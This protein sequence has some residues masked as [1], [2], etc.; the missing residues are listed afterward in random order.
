MIRIIQNSSTV[1]I[2]VCALLVIQL[3]GCGGDT[4]GV[5]DVENMS[6]APPL[7]PDESVTV[8]LSVFLGEGLATADV[9]D[10][11][12][13]VQAS[14]G[15][16][17]PISQ[18]NFTIAAARAAI[19]NAAVGAALTPPAGLFVMAKANDP[20]LQADGSWLWSYSLTYEYF[21][22]D[23]KL[24]G[25]VDG[26]KTY[27]SMKMSVDNPILPI[28]DFEWY[29][30]V[31]TESNLSGS[32]QFFDI[33][34]PEEKN[35]TVEIDWSVEVLK[36]KAELDIQNVDTRSEYL[37]DVLHYNVTSEMASMSFQDVSEG[38][39]W[40]ITWDLETGAGSMTVPGYN[41]GEEACWD[42]QKQDVECN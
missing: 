15:A 5:A 19:V 11:D 41:N 24:T 20:V 1:I 14:P 42:A 21:A 6:G 35:P 10:P 33:Y 30:G 18:Q 3:M 29:S 36:E 16:A 39:T 40:E 13:K 31:C 2:A 8:D 7:P 34:T 28:T 17:T 9:P 32:W 4:D 37:G 23:A 38:E 26:G 27:W 12:E 22:I 25:L